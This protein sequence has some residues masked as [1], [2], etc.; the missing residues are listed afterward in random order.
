[1]QNCAVLFSDIVG[2]SQ[3]YLRYGNKTAEEKIHFIVTTLTACAEKFSGRLVKTIGDEVMCV[4]DQLEDAAEAA[5]EM[6]N[7][8]QASNIELHTGISYGDAVERDGDLFG[9]AVNNAAFLTKAAR[10]KEILIDE[11][12]LNHSDNLSLPN[13][14]LIAEMA[15]KGAKSTCKVYRL[16]WEKKLNHSLGATMVA[17]M[18]QAGPSPSNQLQLYY[19]NQAFT[20][21]TQNPLFVVGRDKTRVSLKISH[22]RISRRHCS[23]RYKQG[24][25]ILEDHSTNGT[26]IETAQTARTR[27]H[28]E[29]YALLGSGTLDLGNDS[30]ECQLRYEVMPPP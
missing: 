29:S 21:D 9:D 26:Y 27:V 2:S 7:L 10:A 15:F 4:F 28:R 24:K 13:I 18:T 20:I 14:E 25:F 22:A 12:A 3:I 11:L 19:N 8:C 1:M 6:N 5:I 16:N 17:G 23:I 30:D